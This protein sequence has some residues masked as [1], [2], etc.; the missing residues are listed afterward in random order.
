MRVI[1]HGPSGE[2]EIQSDEVSPH[3]LVEFKG[4]L[5]DYA[6]FADGAAHYKERVRG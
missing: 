2:F 5:Y 4:R 6:G 3:P 1:L